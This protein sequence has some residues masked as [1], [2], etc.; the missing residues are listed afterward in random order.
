MPIL[1]RSV[2]L[3]G[4][5]RAGL[6]VLIA[7]E[8]DVIVL[9]NLKRE[10]AVRLRFALAIAAAYVQRGAVFAFSAGHLFHLQSGLLLVFPVLL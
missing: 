1:T 9:G 4:K 6:P 3:L 2:L 10:V 5:V 8:P 7:V